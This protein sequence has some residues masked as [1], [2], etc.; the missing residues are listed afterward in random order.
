MAVR[1][2]VK[3]S[4]AVGAGRGAKA[5]S[6]RPLP[7]LPTCVHGGTDADIIERCPSCGGGSKHVRECEVHGTC[8]WEPVNPAVMSCRKCRSENLGFEPDGVPVGAIPPDPRPATV[9]VVVGS[10][11]WPELI[12]LQVRVIRATC[13]PV[14]ILVSGDRPEDYPALARVCAAHPDVTLSPNLER[15]GHT[16][17]D[18]ACFHKGV[19]WGAARGLAVVAKLSQRFV[20]TRPGWLQDGAADLLASGLPLASRRCRGVQ[21]FDLRTE[22]CLL[23]VGAWGRPEVLARVAP[24]RYWADTPKGLAAETVIHR[25][26]LDLL[27][28]VYWPWRLFGEERYARDSPDVLWHNHTPAAEYRTLAEK[29]GVTLPADFTCAGWER[30]EARGEYRHG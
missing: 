7:A 20:V 5:P 8:T 3:R 21:A 22:A 19:V 13:G 4:G 26:L 11:K 15:I 10:Y 9:G 12:D 30:E 27:G 14:P 18:V 25:V 24:R 17:G 28:G 29:H 23:D 16:G 2:S 1:V 6:P